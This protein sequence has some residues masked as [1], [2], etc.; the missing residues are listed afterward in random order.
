MLRRIAGLVLVLAFACT[1]AAAAACPM[2]AAGHD[3]GPMTAMRMVM[4]SH[5]DHPSP[6]HHPTPPSHPASH[7]HP[8]TD[9]AC[10]LAMACGAAAAVVDP[11]SISRPAV[12]ADRAPSLAAGRY[13][14]PVLP[15]DPPPPRSATLA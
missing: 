1:Q 2:R 13:A 12:I 15:A 3:H 10:P 14:S 8:A 9:A 4:P 5:A 11:P 7:H 6:L